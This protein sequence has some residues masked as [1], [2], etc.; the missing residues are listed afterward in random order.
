MRNRA[1]LAA[2]LV[3]MLLPSASAAASEASSGIDWSVDHWRVQTSLYSR[4]FDDDPDHSDSH[5]LID[6]EIWNASGWHAGL[7]FFDN[8]YGQA[9]QYLYV[10]K[11]WELGEPDGFYWRLTGGLL[12]GYKDEY[13]NKI[14][15]ND[16]GVA[17]AFV[18][19]LG[20][21]YKRVFV[22][23]QQLGVAAGVITAGF[24]FGE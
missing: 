16:L 15:L 2:I 3:L 23:Y 4:H 21:R 18:P 6:L 17:P 24:T 20:W 7:A 12:H 11:A 10:G 19:S 14:P 5:Q 13:E 9:S 22:E 1:V 8:S